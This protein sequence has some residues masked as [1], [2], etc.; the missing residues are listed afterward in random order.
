MD[1][2]YLYS[3]GT[4]AWLALQAAPLALSPTMMV[5]MLSPQVREP[6]PLEEYFSRSLSMALL[7]LGILT[8]ILTGS[9]PLTSSF[10]DVAA[11]ANANA[12]T[13]DPEDPKAPYALPTLTITAVYHS[14]VAFYCYSCWST[15]GSL[16]FASGAVG[17][18]TL[19]AVGLWCILFASSSGRISRKTG[20]DKRTSAWPL[21]NKVAEQKKKGGRK[22]L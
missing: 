20:L 5:T 15:I 13:T 18:A 4:A 1:V 10:S 9:V 12:V 3:Y 8:V 11:N 7:A 22:A 19:A 2:Y 17:S 6:S 16:A 21:A 14:A